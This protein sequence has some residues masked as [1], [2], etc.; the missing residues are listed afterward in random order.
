MQDFRANE[1]ETVSG[2]VRC[3]EINY[4]A[5]VGLDVHNCMSIRCSTFPRW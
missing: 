2:Q 5:Y 1:A 3:S 4:A